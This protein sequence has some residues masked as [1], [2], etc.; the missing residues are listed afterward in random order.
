MI[1]K[2]MLSITE[3]T[4]GIGKNYKYNERGQVTVIENEKYKTDFIYDKNGELEN[5]TKTIKNE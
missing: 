3:I 1:P 5:Q 4:V 2:K